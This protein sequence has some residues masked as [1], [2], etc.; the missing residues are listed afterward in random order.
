MSTYKPSI[1]KNQIFVPLT[2]VARLS[3]IPTS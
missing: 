1:H 3:Q 2:D